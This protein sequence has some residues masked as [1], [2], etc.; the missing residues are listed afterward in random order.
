MRTSKV[1][2]GNSRQK[3]IRFC[4]AG[5]MHTI[6]WSGV[7][8]A[9]TA[10]G[11]S[12][13]SHQDVGELAGTGV[14]QP[15]EARWLNRLVSIPKGSVHAA[16]ANREKDTPAF[17]TRYA[18]AIKTAG[19][20]HVLDDEH[21]LGTGEKP[22]IVASLKGDRVF[23]P[24]PKV[25]PVALKTNSLR[26]GFTF[27]ASNS[28]KFSSD[29]T[30]VKSVGSI[31][32]AS[33]NTSLNTSVNTGVNTS[34][35]TGDMAVPHHFAIHGMMND[36]QSF[37][38]DIRSKKLREM[39]LPETLAAYAQVPG[40]SPFIDGQSAQ[41][42]LANFE[43]NKPLIHTTVLA[44]PLRKPAI[45]P[46]PRVRLSKGHLD[47][48]RAASRVMAKVMEKVK[49]QSSDTVLAS[50]SAKGKPNSHLSAYAPQERSIAS[51]FAAVLRPQNDGRK[52]VIKLS[53][54]DHR[55]AAN[56]LPKKAFSKKSR[57]CLA[58]GIYFE[59]R[60]EPIKGQQAV[61]QVILNRVKNPAYPNTVCG[62]VYQNRHKRNRCQFSFTC[63]GIRDKVKSRSNWATAVDIANKSIEGRIWLRSVG[64]SSHYHADY[65]WPRWRRK[66]K[67]MTKIGRHIFYRTYGGGW[68]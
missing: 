56:P 67:K 12:T 29:D 25:T 51:A 2:A 37:E 32:V 61:A 47:S 44:K 60:G 46:K 54:G 43:P 66:M 6:F 33:L 59:A 4:T 3:A 63:D 17:A 28:P 62:V 1:A 21:D 45:Y 64:S 58:I 27:A 36:Y 15:Q 7:V 35:N 34:A 8:L 16:T 24:K 13:V 11:T 42:R 39:T 23:K 68:S 22:V 5:K 57:Q 9:A 38:A 20:T 18:L 48:A 14:Y 26:S 40:V 65:V 53:R 49:K 55:W 30:S 52:S 50:A 31:R 10:V 19:G 41:L